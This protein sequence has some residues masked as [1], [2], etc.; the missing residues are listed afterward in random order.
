[1]VPVCVLEF[2]AER[3]SEGDFVILFECTAVLE[4]EDEPESVRTIVTVTVFV[5]VPDPDAESDRDPVPEYVLD[6]EG[7]DDPVCNDDLEPDV[8]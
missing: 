4:Y 3:V 2:L 5:L 7:M 8:Q 1:V 6:S